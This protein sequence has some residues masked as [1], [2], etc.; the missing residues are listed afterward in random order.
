MD[1]QD[2]RAIFTD[3]DLDSADRFDGD[4]GN[5]I[6]VPRLESE[7]RRGEVSNKETP[8]RT[9]E[10][11]KVLRQRLKRYKEVPLRPTVSFTEA[12]EPQ[13]VNVRSRKAASFSDVLPAAKKD[14]RLPSHDNKS[15]GK[16]PSKASSGRGTKRKREKSVELVSESRQ[17]LKDFHFYFIPNNDINPVRKVQ[18]RNAIKY[19]AT[20]VKDWSE[21]ITHVIADQDLLYDDVKKWINRNCVDPIPGDIAMVNPTYQLD[22]IQFQF[23]VNPRQSHYYIKGY[24]PTVRPEPAATPAPQIEPIPSS[25]LDEDATKS[26][27]TTVAGHGLEDD[28]PLIPPHDSVVGSRRQRTPESSWSAVARNYDD[29][30]SRAIEEAQATKDLVS[31]SSS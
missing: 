29:D 1:L 11:A 5:E 17:V 18:I 24:K 2:K 14:I 31:V 13:D 23:K 12:S 7:S 30:L 8:K 4:D 6:E 9:F 22:C 19:G 27:P 10:V 16:N 28:D 3:F 25:E 15:M 21:G 26:K 20:W